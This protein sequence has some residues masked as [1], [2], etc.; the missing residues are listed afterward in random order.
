[1]T[2]QDLMS[3]YS[4]AGSSEVRCPGRAAARR[5]RQ[6]ERSWTSPSITSASGTRHPILKL[7]ID[8]LHISHI[9]GHG[10]F[11]NRSSSIHSQHYHGSLWLGTGIRRETLERNMLLPTN[12]PWRSQLQIWHSKPKSCRVWSMRTSLSYTVSRM[13]T[14]SNL[15]RMAPFFWLRIYSLK[16]SRFD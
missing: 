12:I 16:P 11:F 14:W 4:E 15:S 3:D 6:F 9:L 1:M 5:L 7:S 2:A 13:E 8:D 10:A